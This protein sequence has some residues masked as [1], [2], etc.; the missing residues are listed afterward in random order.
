MNT[1]TTHIPVLLQEAVA[2]LVHRPDG[3]YVDGTFGRGGHSRAILAQLGPGGRLLAYD[4]DPQAIAHAQAVM[5]DARFEIRHASFDDMRELPAQ[6]VDGILLDLG[7][8]SPQID[9][10]QR[11]FSFRHDGPLDMRMDTTRGQ[12]AA[13][14]LA[15]A[16]VQQIA[17]VIRDYG[18]ER[19]AAQ[20]AKAIVARRQAHGPLERTSEL[21][22]L[23][24]GAV[25]TREPGQDPATRTFQAIRIFVNA[26]LEALQQALDAALLILKPGGVLA[27]ISFHSLEDRIVKQFMQRHSREELDRRLPAIAQRSKTSMLLRDVKRVRP[28]QEEVRTNPRA[29]SAILRTAVRSQEV[30]A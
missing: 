8:S 4:K 25:K 13:D 10:P 23:V 9:T 21:A 24:A 7:V 5:D 26:E 18:E 3:S 17:E 30:L 6:S 15:T 1:L 29:R 11:G 28:S 14:W 27:V 2:A 16:D 20:I 19:F 22:Q 12:S